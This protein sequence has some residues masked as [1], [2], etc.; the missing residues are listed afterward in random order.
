[1]LSVVE[2]FIHLYNVFLSCPSA[3][4]CFQFSLVPPTL[5]PS[6]FV[7]ISSYFVIIINSLGLIIINVDHV[8]IDGGDTHCDR[9]RVIL[10]SSGTINSP[11]P[12]RVHAGILTGLILFRSYAGNHSELELIRATA[13]LCPGDSTSQLCPLSASSYILPSYSSIMSPEP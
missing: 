6:S 12:D 13:L 11:S 9:G 2:H 5:A 10:L 8:N 4:S 7:F 3:T 1:M